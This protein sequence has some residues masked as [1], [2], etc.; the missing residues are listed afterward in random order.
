M[1]V[2]VD[3]DTLEP[4]DSL[5]EAY[6]GHASASSAGITKGIRDGVVVAP[7]TAIVWNS[8]P[9]ALCI[10]VNRTTGL[11]V[12]RGVGHYNGGW[13]VKMLITSGYALLALPTLK[14]TRS[15]TSALVCHSLA[16]SC[17]RRR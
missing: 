3:G 9:F 10:V 15:I 6:L 17:A 14:R 2:T 5:A 13:P 7:T 8:S 11:A 16:Q 4:S 1:T 12:V